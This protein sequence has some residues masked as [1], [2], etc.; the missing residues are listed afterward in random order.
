[1]ATHAGLGAG[2]T[3]DEVGRLLGS[4]LFSCVAHMYICMYVRKYVII[5]VSRLVLIEFAVPPPAF[6]WLH[7][8]HRSAVQN[9]GLGVAHPP[10]GESVPGATEFVVQS[11][12]FES[13]FPH[14]F[15]LL[16]GDLLLF[17]VPAFVSFISDCEYSH[18]L[19]NTLVNI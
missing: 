9:G 18:G 11:G 3:H 10:A 7:G 15:C 19:L 13:G 4:T 2:H 5:Y 17:S 1:M 12:E 6:V 16:P 14:A 8:L